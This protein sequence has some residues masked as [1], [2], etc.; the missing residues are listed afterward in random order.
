M[1]SFKVSWQLVK[2]QL[3]GIGS[4][5]LLFPV[6]AWFILQT[7][8]ENGIREFVDQS[9]QANSINFQSYERY[10]K[11]TE[12]RIKKAAYK[13][14]K[15]VSGRSR[16]KNWP[17][18]TEKLKAH[19]FF[20]SQKDEYLRAQ[21]QKLL[22][23]LKS[24]QKAALPD[25]KN[26]EDWG[27]QVIY[28]DFLPILKFS[29][30]FGH[31]TGPDLERLLQ[32][33]FVGEKQSLYG[34]LRMIYSLYAKRYTPDLR[35]EHYTIKTLEAFLQ[36]K[37]SPE[38]PNFREVSIMGK[39]Y[40]SMEL[41]VPMHRKD[42][43][44]FLKERGLA[45]YKDSEVY[46]GFLVTN[47]DRVK[48][49]RA[50]LNNQKSQFNA[51][52]ILSLGEVKERLANTVQPLVVHNPLL[53]PPPFSK[54]NAL[55]I[56]EN[57]GNLKLQFQS[58]GKHVFSHIQRSRYD[59]DQFLFRQTSRDIILADT[60]FLLKLM[61]A[62]FLLS[63]LT[64]LLWS[65]SLS[66]K[67]TTPLKTLSKLLQ[68]SLNQLKAEDFLIDYD[69][70]ELELLGDQYHGLVSRN[71]RHLLALDKL[72]DLQSQLMICFEP[73]DLRLVASQC[74]ESRATDWTSYFDSDQS[75]ELQGL[76]PDG[77]ESLF[78]QVLQ[79]HKRRILGSSQLRESMR[80]QRELEQTSQIQQNLMRHEELPDW[81]F[82]TC[83]LSA[84]EVAGDF[85]LVRETENVLHLAIADV[86]GKG[87][88]AALFG[89]SARSYLNVLIERE[90]DLEPVEILA[91]VNR[92]LCS[93]EN[94]ELFC[95]C[96]YMQYDRVNQKVSYASAGHN[97]MLYLRDG[98]L[99]EL[100]AKGL[101]LGL[102]AD[103][104][105]EPKDMD[106]Q[107][108]DL[109]CLYTDGVTEAEDQEKELF[110]M[111]RLNELLLNHSSLG[112]EEMKDQLITQ[113]EN[114]RGETEQSDD[115]SALFLRV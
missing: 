3:L 22:L 47:F 2:I 32:A 69:F 48:H 25:K 93:F 11:E 4:L 6:L 46:K 88:A 72:I 55:S 27:L 36:V 108:G 26:L 67:L 66:D 59:K 101:P 112:V 104:P 103:F 49:Y 61:L 43:E 63:V 45:I 41:G 7:N 68:R 97:L 35:V 5:S 50:W 110:G 92:Y 21:S 44:E 102:F 40:M 30:R 109:F 19:E 105:F 42:R 83:Y 51:V 39:N 12:I 60:I 81:D 75:S 57:M 98:S 58:E 114:F 90:D 113:I 17:D 86:S 64:L 94:N 82:S 29:H 37:I 80:K 77:Y 91:E 78:H 65:L 56:L 38:Q 84:L 9:E 24:I 13:V 18:P 33:V 62:F 16:F 85:Y 34:P 106:V 73:K 99:H 111:D 74:M 31:L 14:R 95:T 8:L 96:F 87:Y 20:N 115:I 23:P 52:E 89:A 1:N 100:N 54:D 107:T 71:Q 10:W 70:E 79:T 15:K 76:V 28:F 53:S